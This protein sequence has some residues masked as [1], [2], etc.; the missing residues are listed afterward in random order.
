MG[1]DEAAAKVVRSLRRERRPRPTSSRSSPARLAEVKGDD[2]DALVRTLDRELDAAGHRHPRR[3][4]RRAASRRATSPPCARSLALAERPH[5]EHR[6]RP[7]R[8]TVLAGAHLTPGDARELREHRR[9]VRPAAGRSCRTSRALD[10]SR[11]GSLGARQR[12]APRWPRSAS[13]AR[14][15]TRSCSA[16]RSSRPRARC[17]SASARRTR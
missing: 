14:S 16:P 4:L 1:S 7:R 11:D 8:V 3:R 6:A 12:A 9:G 2:I 15:A 10:G 13:W 17:A 5:A